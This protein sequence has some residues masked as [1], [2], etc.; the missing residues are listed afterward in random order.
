MQVTAIMEA[1]GE[2]LETV[3]GLLAVYDYIPSQVAVPCA[4]TDYPEVVN[5]DATY[6]GAATATFPIGLVVSKVDDKGARNA[7]GEFFV[8]VK[9]AIDGNL[10]GVV[11]DAR[12][13]EGRVLRIGFGGAD[14][15]TVVFLVDIIT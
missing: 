7:L 2:A 11:D 8:N 3:P 13:T 1:L 15:L 9:A 12:V 5:Y 4:F 14:Y 6:G 10:G